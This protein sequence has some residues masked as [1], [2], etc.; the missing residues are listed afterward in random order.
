MLPC[1]CPLHDVRDMAEALDWVARQA[2]AH[3][4]LVDVE[5]GLAPWGAPADRIAGALARA[6]AAIES[7]PVRHE[8]RFVS[9]AR[10]ENGAAV[11]PVVLVAAARKPFTRGLD[12]PRGLPR[13]VIGDQC[14]TDG[15]L[16]VRTRATFVRLRF[17]NGHVPLWPRLQ[18]I[19]GW[20][21]RPLFVRV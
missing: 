3:L 8:V 21:V 2:Q 7:M 6:Q 13:I 9:N 5:P 4:V 16:A 1:R 17:R 11:A 18:N 14:L 12:S 10:F 20:L 15:L 19:A